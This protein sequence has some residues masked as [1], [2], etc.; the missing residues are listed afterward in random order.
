METAVRLLEPLEVRLTH[1][2]QHGS[3][4]SSSNRGGSS[5][6][7]PDAAAANHMHCVVSWRL[8]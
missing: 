8:K 2:H 1:L 6:S 5:S 4:G 7:S 3:S